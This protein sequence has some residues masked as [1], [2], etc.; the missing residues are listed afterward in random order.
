M[1]PTERKYSVWQ[2]KLT[3]RDRIHVI[4]VGAIVVFYSLLR[5][6][7]AEALG[8]G[9]AV[10]DVVL[11]LALGL[12][13]NYP[14]SVAKTCEVDDEWPVPIWL[15]LYGLVLLV[16]APGYWLVRAFF[17][18]KIGLDLWKA[19]MIGMLFFAI[20]VFIMI[21]FAPDLVVKSNLTDRE[22]P[23]KPE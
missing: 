1:D 21:T 14:T 19:D 7:V 11:F 18:E 23:S 22:P 2:V 10:V 3:K 12:T 16:L 4:A 15:R 6:N 5:D 20:S 9:V 17:P 13:L 8:A